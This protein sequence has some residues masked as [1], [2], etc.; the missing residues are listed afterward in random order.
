VNANKIILNN[1][2][3]IDLTQDTAIEEDVAEGKT[4]HK[5]DGS[6]GVGVAHV[7]AEDLNDVLTEQEEL[8][9]ELKETLN[10]KTSGSGGGGS[11]TSGMELNI[12][13]GDD[14]PEDTSKLWIKCNEPEDV[15]IMPP[16]LAY[17]NATTTFGK[18]DGEIVA[19][20]ISLDG[21]GIA[22]VGSAVFG[23]K[24]YLFGGANHGTH[25]WV[26]DTITET[27]T[28]LNT[29]LP[30]SVSQPITASVGTKVYFLSFSNLYDKTIAMFDVETE[31]V[32]ILNTTLP[33]NLNSH[34]V[35]VI[36][37]KIYLFGGETSSSKYVD[38]IYEFD[39]ETEVIKELS[40]TLPVAMRSIA[41]A[42]IGTKVYLF[43]GGNSNTKFNSILV[44][45]AETQKIHSLSL[46]LPAAIWG[47]TCK[48]VNTKVYLFG[49]A[50]SSGAV[51]VIYEFDPKTETIC[52]LSTTLPSAGALW[53]SAAVGGKVYL[54]NGTT[55]YAFLPPIL[56]LV[57]SHLFI[58]ESFANNFFALL[59]NTF[60]GVGRVYLGDSNNEGK[61]VEAMLYQNVEWIE[62]NKYFTESCNNVDSDTS[63][64]TSI[65]C[66]IGDLV[67]AA[68]ATRDTLEISDGWTLVSTSE[69]NSADTTNGQQLS[70]AY[71][72]AEST[73]ESVTVTQATA[74]RLYINMVALQGATSVTDVG[75]SYRN[76]TTNGSLTVDKPDGLVLWG[77]SSPMWNTTSPYPIWTASNDMPIVQLGSSTQSRLGIGLDQSNDET[78]TFTAG[79]S[80]TTI[81]V[82]ALTVEGMDEFIHNELHPGFWESI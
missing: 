35:A 67:V 5:A 4:F 47:Q 61:E 6:V 55:I 63:L 37:T 34:A 12:A 19:T 49:G 78:V 59:P 48:L 8:L 14:P 81:I 36:G 56:R 51:S 44:F 53:R 26:V 52:E 79:A 70:W 9:V 33:T 60:I 29:E 20:N 41:S 13:Y 66:N 54:I 38:K 57:E 46:S 21:V 50:T 10:D 69:I 74:Q 3:L 42:V 16:S 39:T 65:D 64:T 80:T 73:T 45:D 68:I 28:K 1:E 77:M 43:G 30:T 32:A 58:E 17:A 31:E 27:A 62:T 71:K 72:F 24:V 25:I 76:D 15:R 18:D 11:E 82:G 75:Y 7:G 22:A 23:T 40:T 2:V